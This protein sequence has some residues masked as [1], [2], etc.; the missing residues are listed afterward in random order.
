MVTEANG[1]SARTLR[2]DGSLTGKTSGSIA[3]IDHMLEMPSP[4]LQII[5]N[6]GELG[7]SESIREQGMPP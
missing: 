1:F 7:D 6:F 3:T 5:G 2:S 4:S